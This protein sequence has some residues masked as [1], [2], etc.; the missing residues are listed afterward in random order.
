MHKKK[1]SLRVFLV[2]ICLFALALAVYFVPA[3]K[4]RV[5]WNLYELKSKLFYFFNPP[6]EDSFTPGQQAQIAEIVA[7]SQTA[8]AL[9]A[10]DTP[11]PTITPTGV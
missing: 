6:G 5:D 2:I 1:K 10:T 9:E 8:V 11:E 4:N 3:V 7:K